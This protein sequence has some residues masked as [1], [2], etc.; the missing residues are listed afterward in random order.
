MQENCDK[1]Y[2]IEKQ[3]QLKQ[4]CIDYLKYTENDESL[5]VGYNEIKCNGQIYGY[6]CFHA[7][8]NDQKENL[9]N[10]YNINL[11]WPDV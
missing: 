9:I 4:I 8:Y 3:N 11:I 6:E 7:I 2:L 5:Y 1:T 10:K